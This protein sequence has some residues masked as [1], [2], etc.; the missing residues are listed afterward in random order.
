MKLLLKILE[1]QCLMLP[2]FETR[3]PNWRDTLEGR[4]SLRT[5]AREYERRQRQR[6]YR[7]GS[8]RGGS[9]NSNSGIDYY[10]DS[11]KPLYLVHE[12]IS[13]I[14]REL[15]DYHTNEVS[16]FVDRRERYVRKDL[17]IFTLN[18]ILCPPRN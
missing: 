15:W 9:N 10:Y 5:T 17:N 3:N 18:A 14:F 6:A 13:N 2:G 4:R 7:Q 11:Q 8:Q 12:D 1:H 16:V